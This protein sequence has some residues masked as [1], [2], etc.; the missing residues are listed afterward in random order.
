ME[1]PRMAT[2]M[3][4]ILGASLGGEEDEKMDVDPPKQETPPPKKPTPPPP[5]RAE[6]ELPPEK[7]EAAR[8]K[9]LGNDAYKKKDFA[10][11]LEHYHKAITADPTDIT[12]YN[13]IAGKYLMF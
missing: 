3:K 12:F 6:S 13:N 10:K 7:Q 8:E 4:V 9:A 11:A 5:S 2:T 1:D